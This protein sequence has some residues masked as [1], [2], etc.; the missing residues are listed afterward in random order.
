MELLGNHT[1]YN[2]GRALAAAIQFGVTARL[3]TTTTATAAAGDAAGEIVFASDAAEPALVRVAV[4]A[5]ASTA[6]ARGRQEGGAAWV[7]YPLGVLHGF[8]SAGAAAGD[9][10]DGP[11]PGGLRFDFSSDLPVGA[12]LSSSAA[13]EVATCLALEKHF[14]RP[15]APLDRAKLCRR[16]ENEFVG[17]PSGLLDQA[18]SVFGRRGHAVL[19]DFRAETVATVPFPPGLGLL[20]FHTGIAHRLVGG[21]YRE[22]RERCLAAAQALGVPALR[23]VSPADLEAARGRLDETTWRR[24]A[25]VVGENERVR[26]G[27]DALQRGDGAAFGELMFQSHESS[28][29]HFENSTPELDALVAAAREISGVLGS[30]LTGG[31]FGGA[32]VSLVENARMDEVAARLAEEY[33][34]RTGHRGRAFSCEISDGAA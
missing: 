30:R 17:V 12:G 27:V 20:V 8:F 29:V 4:A 31:G 11:L 26:R 21:E 22:R 10:D 6:G 34:R 25:H 7:N 3:A 18:T 24:A 16:A 14:D 9:G 1:D 5:T 33:T 15:L 13:I 19:L 2:A 28:R 23:D 32:T